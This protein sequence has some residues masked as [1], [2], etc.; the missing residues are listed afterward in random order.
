MARQIYTDFTPSP[1]CPYCG[2]VER[3]AWEIDFGSSETAT[4]FCG[5]CGRGYVVLQHISITY[6]TS[7][8]DE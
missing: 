8:S 2:H 4:V 6:T 1:V 7:K 3:D 5:A